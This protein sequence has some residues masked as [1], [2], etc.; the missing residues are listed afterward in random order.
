MDL[1]LALQPNKLEVWLRLEMR[2]EW[3]IQK[4][5]ATQLEPGQ[6]L[7]QFLKLQSHR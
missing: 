3:Q 1:R 5:M 2:L 6:H 7:D 4:R